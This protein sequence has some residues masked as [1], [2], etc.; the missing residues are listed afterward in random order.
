M[1]IAG[2]YIRLTKQIQWLHTGSMTSIN[3]NH[4]LIEKRILKGYVYQIQGRNKIILF[5]LL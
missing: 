4:R 3:K 2:A 1:E 5:R